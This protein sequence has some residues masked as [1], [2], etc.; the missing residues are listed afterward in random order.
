[1]PNGFK[2]RSNQKNTFDFKTAVYY[3]YRSSA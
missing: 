2:Y 3:F 1:M